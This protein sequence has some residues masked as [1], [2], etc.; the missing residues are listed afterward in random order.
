MPHILKQVNVHTL[1]GSSSGWLV[2]NDDG[3][4]FIRK[5][6][7]D[8][9]KT[10]DLP[11]VYVLFGDR[12]YLAF[13]SSCSTCDEIIYMGYGARQEIEAW[14]H[15]IR[16]ATSGSGGDD[17]VRPEP[18]LPLVG[19]LPP[20]LYLM[21]MIEHEARG[22]DGKFFWDRIGTTYEDYLH[23]L[24]EKDFGPEFLYATESKDRL[25]PEKVEEYKVAIGQG[26]RPF[27]IGLHITAAATALLDGHHKSTAYHQ[28][29]KKVP[30]LTIAEVNTLIGGVQ[31][32]EVTDWGF[33][34][35]NEVSL[36]DIPKEGTDFE[37]ARNK[38][39]R[40][41]GFSLA[42][43]KRWN[44]QLGIDIATVRIARQRMSR[45]R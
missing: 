24:R 10:P 11:R 36:G 12:P 33:G 17:G 13:D 15:S 14:A 27:G 29:G 39:G 8:F 6:R 2:L 7:S 23:T 28:L 31:P 16:A 19:L 41:S 34:F 38:A 45:R 44:S 26:A 22:P 42:D 32:G 9:R 35:H 25:N 40:D 4:S 43:G 30:I 21:I 37:I 20:A 3:R 1:R 5:A 18:F